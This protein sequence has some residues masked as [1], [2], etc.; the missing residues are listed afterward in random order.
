[1]QAS[2]GSDSV[3]EADRDYFVGE[4]SIGSI[5][6]AEWHSIVRCNNSL[7][8]MKLDTG[9]ATNVMPLKIFRKLVPKPKLTHSDTV[10]KAYGGHH[11]PQ[12][13]KCQLKTKS[14]V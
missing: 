7:I 2:E 8:K 11:I 6:S 10:L 14:A 5:D 12:A 4:L 3:S 1:M 9:A 13:G